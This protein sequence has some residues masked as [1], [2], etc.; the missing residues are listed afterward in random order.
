MSDIIANFAPI[1]V[2]AYKRPHHIV[3][4]LQSLKACPEHAHSPITIYCDGPRSEADMDLVHKTR[5]AIKEYAP[6]HAVIIEREQNLGLADSIITGVTENCYQYGRVIVLEDDLDLS[7]Y[8]L[9]YFNRALNQY[10]HDEKVMHIAGYMFPVDKSGLPESFFYRE[11]SC[12]GWATWQRAW[13]HFEPDAEKSLALIEADPQKAKEFNI[14]NS[15]DYV[16]MLKAHIHGVINSW[17]VRWYASAF[18][19]GGLALHAREPFTSNTGND[20]TGEHCTVTS[21]YDVYVRKHAFNDQW[22][23]HSVL[24]KKA[25]RRIRDFWQDQR[26]QPDTI[27]RITRKIRIMWERIV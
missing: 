15:T 2:F 27:R 17:A 25:F 1:A 10:Q 19:R 21:V 12:W 24:N 16:G 9:D 4:L 8:A 26:A 6:A 20:G 22:P 3:Q 14:D 7:P 13:Q 11:M 18:L 5:M 23:P